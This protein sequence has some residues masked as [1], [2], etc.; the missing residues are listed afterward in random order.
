M[1]YDVQGTDFDAR[2]LVKAGELAKW[3]LNSWPFNK[4]IAVYSNF[5]SE[6]IFIAV[7]AHIIKALY[8]NAATTVGGSAHIAAFLERLAV[9]P[10]R[11]PQLANLPKIVEQC[12]SFDLF[13]GRYARDI[14]VAWLA[15]A[16]PSA[17]FAT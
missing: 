13:P 14:V 10:R 16:T 15:K 8:Y 7:S 5:T 4:A 11:F 6:Y 17:Y 3:D 2:T 9:H 1:G 12:F